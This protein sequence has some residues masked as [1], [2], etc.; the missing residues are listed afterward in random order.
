MAVQGIEN[1]HCYQLDKPNGNSYHYKLI[2][3]PINELLKTDFS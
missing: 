1:D 3:Q 2:Q